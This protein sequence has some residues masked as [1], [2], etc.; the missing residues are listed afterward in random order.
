MAA[1]FLVF[2]SLKTIPGYEERVRTSLFQVVSILTTTGFATADYEKWNPLGQTVIFLL[3][4]IGG[5]AGSTAGNIKVGRYMIILK[6]AKIELEQMLHPK[7]LISLRFGD[8]ILSHD[9]IINVLQYFF[10]YI[11]LILIG[12]LFLGA[13][14]V[15]ILTSFTACITCMGNIGPGFGMVGPVENFS[16]IPYLGKYVLSIL[17]L[18][19]RLKYILL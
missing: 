4:F 17:M 2:I 12:T 3:M 18:L 15:D 19:G 16:D 5:C 6:R 9:L 11:V 14:G 7:A 1:V 8:K 10:L 13:M